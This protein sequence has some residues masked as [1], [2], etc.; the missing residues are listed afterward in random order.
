MEA[1][2]SVYDNGGL[3]TS[4]MT[5]VKL[6]IKP[7]STPVQDSA[8]A[9]LWCTRIPTIAR[10]ASPKCF[11]F[12]GLSQQ[13]GTG[14]QCASRPSCSPYAM[15]PRAPVIAITGPCALFM[16]ISELTLPRWGRI[17]SATT[18][19]SLGDTAA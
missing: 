10:R 1:C 15:I 2:G 14:V 11:P 9:I 16:S 17:T 6:T 3:W 7:P 12:D 4:K 8:I 18:S 5:N 19:C 13:A